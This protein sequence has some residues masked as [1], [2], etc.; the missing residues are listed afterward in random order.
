MHVPSIVALYYIRTELI[1]SMQNHIG[2]MNKK[3]SW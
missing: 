1:A 3:L 2:M